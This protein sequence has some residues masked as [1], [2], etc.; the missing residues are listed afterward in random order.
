MDINKNR[1]YIKFSL[2]GFLKNLRFFDAF[3]ILFLIDKGLTYTDIGILYASREII[4]NIFEVPSGIIAD[5]YGRKSSLVGSFILYILSFIIFYISNDFWMFLM[6]FLLY[7]S[8]D[9]FRSGTHKGMIMSYLKSK[10]WEDRKI[11][12]YGHTRSWSQRGAAVSSLIA[13][14]IVFSTGDYNSIFIIS[15]IPYI[16][17]LFLISS[18]PKELNISTSRKTSSIKFTFQSFY[19]ILK[20]REV[21]N[22]INTA[23]IHTAYLRTVKDYIQ[24]L[25]V[26][27]AV[28]LPFML[29]REPDKKNGIVIGVI[30]FFIYLMTSWGSR[31]SAK[32]H[33]RSKGN[34]SQSSLIIG[35]AF[36][37]LSGVFYYFDLWTLALIAFIGI[38][39]IENIRKP[40]L[41]GYIADNVPNEVLTSVLSIQSLWRTL[42]TSALALIFGLIADYHGIAVSLLAV[43]I[44]ILLLSLIVMS[45]SVFKRKEENK[46]TE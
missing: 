20:H 7:G 37:V 6:A 42:L 18:Y 38:Y 31:F 9:A 30:Y 33:I 16:I 15:T 24:P 45:L 14:L 32:Y 13:G 43:S 26:N 41:T 29:D 23:S 40:I 34:A 17:N 22:I 12:Y 28:I 10:G 2:Y 3:F 4:I 44:L 11:S 27:V 21:L 35:L 36:G 39:V 8:A 25:M 19:D 46:L 5:T 1:Q